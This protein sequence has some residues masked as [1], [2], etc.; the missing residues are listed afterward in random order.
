M[1][2]FLGYRVEH[3]MTTSVITVAPDATLGEAESLFAAHDF[4]LLPVVR[5]DRMRGILTKLD[6]LRAFDF[7]TESIVPHYE[8]IM[9]RPVSAVANPTVVTLPR[10]Y[11]LTRVIDRMVETRWRSF[12]VV[13][14]ERLVGVVSRSDVLLALRRAASGERAD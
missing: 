13:E 4:N 11:P 7:S 14:G 5:G 3:V 9:A 1:Y 10:D 12:P 2:E 8:E 6:L